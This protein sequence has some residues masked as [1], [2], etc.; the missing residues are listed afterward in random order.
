MPQKD[1]RREPVDNIGN[2]LTRTV[3]CERC[4]LA[5]GS[6]RYRLVPAT[7]I[8][9]AVSVQMTDDGIVVALRAI[10]HDLTTLDKTTGSKDSDDWN[11][12]KICAP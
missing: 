2:W 11:H 12:S 7:W 10:E 9:I 5:V 1:R 3:A 8:E 6:A 4:R